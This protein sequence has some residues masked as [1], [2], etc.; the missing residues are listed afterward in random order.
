MRHSLSVTYFIIES[1]YFN[2][3]N[4]IGDFDVDTGI[5]IGYIGITT[6]ARLET[7]WKHS[8]SDVEIER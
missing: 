3:N 6:N 2:L 8:N 4:H 1:K 5:L 7:F